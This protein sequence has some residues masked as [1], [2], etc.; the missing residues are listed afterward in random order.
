[1]IEREPAELMAGIEQDLAAYRECGLL[2]HRGDRLTSEWALQ[3][4]EQPGRFIRPDGTIDTERLRNFRKLLIF[5]KD[6]PSFS[7][8]WWNRWTLLGG[9]RRGSVKMLR[10][11]LALLKTHGYDALLKKHPCS[12][13]GHPYVFRTDGYQFTYRWFRHIYFLGLLQR[14]LGSRLSGELTPPH[15]AGFTELSIGGGYGVFSYVLKREYPAARSILVDFPEQLLLARYFL[16]RSFPQA[17]IAGMAQIAQLPSISREF[18]QAHDFVLVPC[19]YYP[20]LEGGSVDLVTNFISFGEMTPEWFRFYVEAPPFTSAKWF[21]TVNRVQS[22]PVYDSD[23]TILDYPIWDAA[24][25]LHFGLCPALSSYFTQRGVFLME[26]T[27]HAPFF[28]YLGEK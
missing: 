23:L 27:A 6:V 25:R 26:R 18:I 5:L 4:K 1:M 12:M 22:R 10:E 20:R 7:L 16:G 11:N 9:G 28:E 8:Q 15:G 19:Q 24:K 21:F 2:E 14:V 13:V 17:R 3:V